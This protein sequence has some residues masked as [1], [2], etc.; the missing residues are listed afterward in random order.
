MQK[1]RSPSV[2]FRVLQSATL[3]LPSNTMTGLPDLTVVL[4]QMKYV[5]TDKHHRRCH[6]RRDTRK[7]KYPVYAA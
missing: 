1:R 6:E 4:H 3:S 5:W 7:N 2:T